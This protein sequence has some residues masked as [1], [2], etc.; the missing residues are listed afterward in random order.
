MATLTFY[1]PSDTRTVFS[2]FDDPVTDSYDATLGTTNIYVYWDSSYSDYAHYQGSFNVSN[3]ENVTG[4]IYSGEYWDGVKQLSVSVPSGYDVLKYLS[5]AAAHDGRG[6]LMDLLKGNDSLVGS[7]YADYLEGF[8][9]NDTLSGGGGSDTLAGGAGNDVYIVGAGDVVMEALNAGTD[10]IKSGVNRTLGDNQENLTL[11]ETSAINGT[12]NAQNNVLTGN[13]A[14]N[15]LWGAGGA[16]KLSGSGGAD[17]L[18][19]QDGNDT[20]LG[21]T[22]NDTLVGGKGKDILT[23]EGGADVFDFNAPGETAT[24]DNRDVINSFA[25]DDR[26]DLSGID[27]NVNAAN[28]QAF[29]SF[30]Q[31]ANYSGSFANPGMLFYETDTHIL[32]GNNDADSSAD[33]SIKINLS[34]LSTMAKA[35]FIL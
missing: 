4:T 8:A 11:T 21:G 10:L 5:Y 26:V 15:K 33:F 27:A 12:G 20:L 9:G 28:N 24:G 31:G 13:S 1:V 17:Q 30:A 19:G 18:H 35:D 6:F 23:G 29:T 25:A 16:D 7:G 22:G 2:T 14:A 32:W 3:E 34:G